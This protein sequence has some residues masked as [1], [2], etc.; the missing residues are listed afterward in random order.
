MTVHWPWQSLCDELQNIFSS[1]WNMSIEVDWEHLELTLRLW[2]R[3]TFMSSLHGTGAGPII[4]LAYSMGCIATLQLWTNLMKSARRGLDQ[5]SLE[6]LP[7]FKA[8][9]FLNPAFLDSRL[10]DFAHGDPYSGWDPSVLRRK[11]QG[12]VHEVCSLNF[13]LGPFC[14]GTCRRE[15]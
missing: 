8:A 13:S 9:V 15:F 10:S 3:V 7:R 14:S 6:L 12:L 5:R 2:D 11:S 1:F 4:F